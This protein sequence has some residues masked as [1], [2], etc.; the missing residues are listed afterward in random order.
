MLFQCL[1]DVKQNRIITLRTNFF[2]FSFAKKNEFDYR[3]LCTEIDT[4][5]HL[6]NQHR[7]IARLLQF[8]EIGE[9][10]FIVQEYYSN[11]DLASYM[12]NFPYNQN[13]IDHHKKKNQLLP[14]N[15]VVRIFNDIVECLTFVQENCGLYHGAIKPTNIL[16]DHN[17]QIKLIGFCPIFGCSKNRQKSE[18]SVKIQYPEYDE[19]QPPECWSSSSSCSVNIKRHRIYTPTLDVWS[20]GILLYEMLT[21]S[22]PFMART[23]M[24][25]ST[26]SKQIKVI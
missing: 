18:N 25:N 7:N 9:N 6:H 11:G 24:K 17:N 5:K 20:C 16:F 8:D 19:Y 2:H 4:L 12:K 22:K 23:L 10:I 13:L 3:M 1:Q 21:N 14:I 26:I 15:E